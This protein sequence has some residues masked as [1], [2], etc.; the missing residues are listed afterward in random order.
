MFLTTDEMKSV[1]YRYQMDDIVE[2]DESIVE[3][4]IEAATAEVRGYFEAANHRRDT[5]NLTAQQYAAYPIYD[6]NAIF[7]AQGAGR[8]AFVLRCV[9]TVAAWYVCELANP[10]AI[11]SEVKERYENVIK[12]LEKIAGIGEYKDSP[13]LSIGLPTITPEP[14]P[15]P[16]QPFRMGSRIK[17]RHE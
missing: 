1:L 13:A 14:A 12:T 6:V 3:E 5:A 17:F 9:K 10:D 7:A 2:S 8:N 15:E 16:A 4:A 11:Y